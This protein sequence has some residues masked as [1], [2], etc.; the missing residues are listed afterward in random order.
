LEI[1]RQMTAD[2]VHQVAGLKN[3]LDPGIDVGCW[4]LLAQPT[5]VLVDVD[6]Q[7]DFDKPR[8]DFSAATSNG[9]P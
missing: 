6:E 4:L 5:G 2:P 1:L 9:L 3:R 8:A 7:R